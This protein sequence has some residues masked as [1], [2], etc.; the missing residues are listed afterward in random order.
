MIEK[1]R[2]FAGIDEYFT[3]VFTMAEDR[4]YKPGRSTAWG[5]SRIW[6]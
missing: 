3:S 1:S 4:A 6:R 2:E 5:W